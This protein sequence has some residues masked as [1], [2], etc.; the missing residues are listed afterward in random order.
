MREGDKIHVRIDSAYNGK[1]AGH[2][3]Q[4]E[5]TGYA[6]HGNRV[7][8]RLDNRYNGASASGLFW[9]RQEDLEVLYSTNISKELLPM[10]SKTV[11]ITFPSGNQLEYRYNL[12]DD[13]IGLGDTVVVHTAHQGL[14]VAKVTSVDEI[15]PCQVEGREIVC[16]VDL[17]EFEAR[18]EK[19][20]RRAELKQ[21]M[22][23]KVYLIQRDLVYDIMAEK[24][25][26]LAK[27]LAEYKA[28][29]D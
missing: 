2:T 6:G 23:A 11:G 3:G 12:Y 28:L 18:K 26:A 8:V 5:R 25:E 29:G 14:S 15:G 24:D 10:S 1:Y 7:G 17:S 20:R 27:M 21:E 19:A 9:F 13:S 22:D 16:K 4:V